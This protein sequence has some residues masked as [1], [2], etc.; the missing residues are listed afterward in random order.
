MNRRKHCTITPWYLSVLCQGVA[1]ALPTVAKAMM[2]VTA[3][4]HHQFGNMTM[5][6]QSHFIA[7]LGSMH[8]PA[9]SILTGLAVKIEAGRVV[10]DKEHSMGEA[11]SQG[12]KLPPMHSKVTGDASVHKNLLNNR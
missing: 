6:E 1:K 10:C 2:V 9:Q 8:S 12:L 5:R 7:H 11:S 4:L 3:L